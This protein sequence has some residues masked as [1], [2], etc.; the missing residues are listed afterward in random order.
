MTWAA[1]LASLSR[2][3]YLNADSAVSADSPD[4][5]P[6]GTNGTIGKGIKLPNGPLPDQP[7]DLPPSPLPLPPA[8]D[9]PGPDIE[10]AAIQAEATAAMMPAERHAEIVA[11]LL[12]AA[13][14]LAGVPGAR[15]CRSCGRGIWVSPS[16]PGPHAPDLCAACRWT[17]AP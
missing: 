8:D 7:A 15:P 11:G 13:S 12:R 2:T 14:P 6:I 4:F 1:R 16:S 17:S 3:K 10:R 5:R 9:P